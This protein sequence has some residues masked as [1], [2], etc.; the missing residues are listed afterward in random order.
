MQGCWYYNEYTEY[1][2]D[3]EGTAEIG[4]EYVLTKLHEHNEK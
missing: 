1:E 3:G 4:K 2:F